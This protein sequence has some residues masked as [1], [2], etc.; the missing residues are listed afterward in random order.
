MQT[1][2]IALKTFILLEFSATSDVFTVK[3]QELFGQKVLPHV[4]MFTGRRLYMPRRGG[5]RLGSGII[6]DS[7]WHDLIWQRVQDSV[8]IDDHYMIVE[9]SLVW[10]V[11]RLLTY[12]PEVRRA[13]RLLSRQAIHVVFDRPCQ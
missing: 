5:S 13:V 4:W 2:V 11:E 9:E 12:H 6:A 10:K 7:K 8:D 3:L 1:T